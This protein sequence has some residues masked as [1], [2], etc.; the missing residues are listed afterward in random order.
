MKKKIFRIQFSSQ[1]KV[2]EIYARRVDTS[3]IHGFVEVEE[4]L[5]GERTTLVVDPAEEQIKLEFNGVG[6]THIPFHAVIRI[7]EVERE[8]TGKIL[9]LATPSDPHPIAPLPFLQ[10]GKGPDKA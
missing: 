3:L 6:K 8:G 9:H 10:P 2:Y 7:D 1:G 4:I 5:F